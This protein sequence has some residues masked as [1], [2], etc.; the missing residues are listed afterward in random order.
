MNDSTHLANLK[1]LIGEGERNT[2]ETLKLL[3]E[4]EGYKIIQ[5]SS[6]ESTLKKTHLFDPDLILLDGKMA[7]GI[8]GFETCRRLKSDKT[9][10]DIPVIFISSKGEPEE[11]HNGFQVGGVDYITKPFKGEEIRARVKTHLSLNLTKKALE[12]QDQIFEEKVKKRTKEIYDSRLEIIQSLGLTTEYCDHI[13]PSHVLRISNYCALLG[14]ACGMNP[15][16]V[17][18]LTQA[19]PLYDLGKIGIPDNILLKPGKLAPD[20]MNIIHRHVAI[21]TK[22]LSGSQSELINMAKAIAQTHHER[23]DGTGYIKGLK[24]EDI[25]LVGRICSLC[26]VFEALTSNRPYRTA[27]SVEESMTKIKALSSKHFDPNLVKLFKQLLP[28]IKKIKKQF[29]D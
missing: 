12:D 16:E 14:L 24:G 3:L 23:W 6:G 22:I 7:E 1:I 15:K 28:D 8:S 29:P 2:N 25:P 10:R 4:K 13:T 11:T 18:L 5:A 9:T 20:E 17:D 19:S 21:G 27:L 26:S